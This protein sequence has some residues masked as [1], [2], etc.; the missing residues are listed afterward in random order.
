MPVDYAWKI[1]FW[2][3]FFSKQPAKLQW[4]LANGE[5][6]DHAWPGPQEIGWIPNWAAEEPAPGYASGR[7]LE[8]E[9]RNGWN[10]W[11]GWNGNI[12]NLE[13]HDYDIL[14][15][16]MTS[17]DMSLQ[18]DGLVSS[19]CAK[20]LS[21]Q[22]SKHAHNLFRLSSSSIFV[23]PHHNHHRT[24]TFVLQVTMGTQWNSCRSYFVF[25]ENQD[26]IA[27]AT[28]AAQA[29]FIGCTDSSRWCIQR[30][31]TVGSPQVSR[32]AMT[33]F[34]CRSWPC[35]PCWPCSEA[36]FT[37]RGKRFLAAVGHL[38]RLMDRHRS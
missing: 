15:H 27:Q 14:W 31:M 3:F 35:R 6:Q 22:R 24:I 32:E 8:N 33:S 9:T 29:S 23:N 19:A 30:S 1:E 28:R 12:W 16:P 26:N 25:H 18:T 4:H 7:P 13:T 21:H 10:G 17:Y 11:D 36:P 20:S 2:C 5:E 38:Q 37:W 34:A